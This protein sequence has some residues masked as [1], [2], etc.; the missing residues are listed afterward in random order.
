MAEYLLGHFFPF[1]LFFYLFFPSLNLMKD[2]TLLKEIIPN[3][4][5]MPI[6]ENSTM[7]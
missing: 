6:S 5:Q 7:Y 1:F 2:F 4:N 3:A